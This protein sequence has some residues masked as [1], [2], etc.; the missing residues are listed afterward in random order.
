LKEGQQVVVGSKDVFVTEVVFSKPGAPAIATYLH[1]S[2]VGLHKEGHGA[3]L[4][5]VVWTSS[6]V[7]HL[8]PCLFGWF[9]LFTSAATALGRLGNIGGF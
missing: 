5:E 4:G 8:I 1:N 7:K 9:F 3:L 6:R 2:V